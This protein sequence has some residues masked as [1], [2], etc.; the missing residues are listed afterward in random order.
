MSVALVLSGGGA[1]ASYQVGV[2]SAVSDILG[3]PADNPFQVICGTSAGAFNAALLAC[4]ADHFATGVTLLNSL[5]AGL[6]SDDVH[7]IGSG[8]ILSSV[9]GLIRSMFNDGYH[10]GV[11]WSLLNNGP[12]R[13][14]LGKVIRFDR[15]PG[16]L[17]SGELEALAITALGY[18]SGASLSFFEG[19]SALKGWRRHRRIGLPVKLR[20]DHL[21][22]S[23]AIPGIYPSVLI[24]REF[25]GDG[26]VRQTA[27]LSPALHLGATKIFAIGVSHNPS[28]P[29]DQ[30]EVSMHTP[31]FAQMAT[32]FLNGSF[33]DALEEDLETLLR[34]NEIIDDLPVEKQH[35]QGL[36]KVDVMSITPSQRFD[37]LAATHLKSLPRSMRVLFRMLG[38]TRAGGGASLAS[39]LL[40]EAPFIREL[41]DCGYSDAMSREVEI[42]EFLR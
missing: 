7:K 26:A 41:I 34:M 37:E 25:F 1:R 3:S 20:I 38:A 12:L 14:L 10:E 4:E 36:R 22:A 28:E 6:D 39:Y 42:S 29:E 2:L 21:M 8:A 19:A 31:S 33:I 15:L 11:P 32:Q 13:E 23:S 16:L 40:F 5:W 18:T 27:P 30:R 35:K 17:D 9:Y 24:H